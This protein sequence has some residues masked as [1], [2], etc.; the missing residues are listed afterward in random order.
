[1]TRTLRGQ[2]ALAY[3]EASALLDTLGPDPDAQRHWDELGRAIG[4]TCRIPD[5][6][7]PTRGDGMCGMHYRRHRRGTGTEAATIN[8]RASR[9][10][11]ADVIDLL[12]MGERPARIPHRLGASLAAIEKALR[13][14]GHDEVARVFEVERSRERAAS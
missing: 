7:A 3:L 11:A 9:D 12:D 13:R 6:S 1:M 14:T 5:C 2:A 4:R 8:R 10:L